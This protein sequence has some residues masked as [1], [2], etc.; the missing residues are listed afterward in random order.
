MAAIKPLVVINGLVRELP[1][2]SATDRPAV[3]V[4]YAA[5]VTLDCDSADVFDVTLT[6]NTTI[7]LS[8]G[9]DGRLVVLRITQ[10]G[11][12]GFIA[13]WGAMVRFGSDLTSAV[14]TTAT[15]KMDKVGLRLHAAS[16]KYDVDALIKGF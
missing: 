5:A 8:G 3:A 14:L 10:G 2:S 13:S 9:V 4:G 15:G 16:G 1:A 7:S 12:G 6:G 11:A